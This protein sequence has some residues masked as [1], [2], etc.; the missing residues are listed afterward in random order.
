[1]NLPGPPLSGKS[2]GQPRG[3]SGASAA[4]YAGCK[5]LA[6]FRAW[7]RRGIMPG[8][9]PGTRRY[10]RRA[11]DLALDRLSLITSQSSEQSAYGQWKHQ[12]AR[13]AQRS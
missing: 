12:N 11:I 4:A 5:T 10:D 1:M 6:A 9:I 3:L 8:P 13:T 2:A 7:V